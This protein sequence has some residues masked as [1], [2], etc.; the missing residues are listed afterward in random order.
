[1]SMTV[2]ECKVNQYFGECHPHPQAWR[3]LL[4]FDPSD[5]RQH[6]ASSAETSR[7]EKE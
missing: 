2:Y 6:S 3:L 1:M 5:V 7:G 4:V